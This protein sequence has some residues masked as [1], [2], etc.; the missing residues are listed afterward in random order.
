MPAQSPSFSGH[1]PDCFF[2]PLH[3][4]QGQ[5]WEVWGQPLLEEGCRER[6]EV[7]SPSMSLLEEPVPHHGAEQAEEEVDVLLLPVS[8]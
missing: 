4:K 7:L 2:T 3:L 5:E 6:R 8:H 1:I